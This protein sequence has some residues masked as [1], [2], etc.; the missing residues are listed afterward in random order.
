MV[1]IEQ[2]SQTVRADKCVMLSGNGNIKKEVD[3]MTQ[4][5][6]GDYFPT[7]YLRAADI[8]VDT[9]VTIARI[10]DAIMGDD[11]KPVVFFSEFEKGLVLNKTNGLHIAQL[12]GSEKFSEWVGKQITLCQMPVQFKGE[13]IQAIRVKAGSPPAS[14]SPEKTI[15]EMEEWEHN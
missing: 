10:E 9:T 7:K 4:D 13:V 6:I 1:S 15:K 5:S 12:L 8:K 3:R 2:L 11:T 14:F